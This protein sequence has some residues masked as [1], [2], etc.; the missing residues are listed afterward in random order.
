[1]NHLARAD[2][3][4]SAS[5]LSADSVRAAAICPLIRLA[6]HA[7]PLGDFNCEE[8]LAIALALLGGATL[9][10]LP[11]GIR[12]DEMPTFSL[13]DYG[14]ET[15]DSDDEEAPPA[16]PVGR[17]RDNTPVL[18]Q[19]TRAYQPAPAPAPAPAVKPSG[20]LPAETVTKIDKLF[21]ANTTL[22]RAKSDNC[23]ALAKQVGC[24]P[25]RLIAEFG[26]RREAAASC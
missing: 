1:L 19:C 18:V 24:T 26:K 17:V 22:G 7:W 3:F 10:G 23:I 14:A 5:L 16:A 21:K 9:P 4:S 12:R 20:A 6:R 15:S 25:T 2:A 11:E 13:G 8:E